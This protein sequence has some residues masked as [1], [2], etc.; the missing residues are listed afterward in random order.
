MDAAERPVIR[1]SLGLVHGNVRGFF[2]HRR[3]QQIGGC[4]EDQIARHLVAEFVEAAL[5]NNCSRTAEA[6][7]ADT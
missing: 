5:V 6:A 4:A 3:F 2:A 7:D 1:L